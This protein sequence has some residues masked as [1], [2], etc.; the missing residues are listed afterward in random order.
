MIDWTAFFAWVGRA[1]VVVTPI[2]LAVLWFGRTYIDKWLAKR[3]QGQLDALKHAQAL[4]FAK[5]KLSFDAKLHRATQLHEREFDILPKTW[6]MLGA[7]GGSIR[8]LISDDQ[9]H[10]DV[11]KLDALALASFL[12]PLPISE[13]EKN[14]ITAAPAA[15]RTNLFIERKLRYQM[16]DASTRAQNFHNYV[17]TNGVFVE[18]ALRKKLLTVSEVF[19]SIVRTHSNLVITGGSN[20]VDLGRL[21]RQRLETLDKLVGEIGDEISERIWGASK[22]DA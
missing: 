20:T 14:A 3:F 15:K 19:E 9:T 6:E 21:N 1:A 12:D 17:A 5:H 7:T 22:L 10:T 18:P 16:V 13:A 11:G 2:G 4:E 8:L